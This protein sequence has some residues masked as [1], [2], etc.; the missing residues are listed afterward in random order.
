MCKRL[1][2]FLIIALVFTCGRSWANAG[3]LAPVDSTSVAIETECPGFC[4]TQVYT[5]G[6]NVSR[7]FDYGTDRLEVKFHRVKNTFSLTFNRHAITTTEF[8][9]RLDSTVF[10]EG[11]TCY[12]Y[13]SSPTMCVVYD[14]VAP[15]PKKGVDYLGPVTWTLVY[16]SSDLT[17]EPAFAH[18]KGPSCTEPTPPCKYTENILQFYSTFPETPSDGGDDPTMQGN[19]DG[20]SSVAAVREPGGNA[21]YCNFKPAGGTFH[22][23]EE[24]DVEFRLTTGP[25]CTGTSIR[26]AI[27]RL[28]LALITDPENPVIEPVR[29]DDNRGNRFQF[30]P[31]DQEYEFDLST[32]GLAPGRYAITV[33]SNKS[34]PK[35]VTFFLIP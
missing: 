35:T 9:A 22:V 29:S 8:N 20:L 13:D 23:G 5:P 15:L 6:D 27:A 17:G 26:N 3:S 33:I 25:N 32:E 2:G 28:S 34:S 11:S 1:F 12:K 7:L 31:E 30:D 24:I 14:G 16:H 4:I 18:A 10:P 19:S 21:N